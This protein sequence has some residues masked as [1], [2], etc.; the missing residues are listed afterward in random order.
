MDLLASSATA[1]P[2]VDHPAQGLAVAFILLCQ[3]SIE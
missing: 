3:I 1:L 2:V